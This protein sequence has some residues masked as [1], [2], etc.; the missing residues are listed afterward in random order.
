MFHTSRDSSIQS[1]L[2]TVQRLRNGVLF[3]FFLVGTAMSELTRRSALTS[4]TARL[5]G[6]LAAPDDARQLLIGDSGDVI[7]RRALARSHSRHTR[8]LS[9]GDAQ[10]K[11]VS[12]ET[13]TSTV[14][15]TRKGHVQYHI[16]K[17]IIAP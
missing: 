6:S 1:Y 10:T 17:L 15:Y 3:L 9:P 16:G 7:S 13:G 4:S 12:S 11:V 8:M 5:S 2:E 14:A